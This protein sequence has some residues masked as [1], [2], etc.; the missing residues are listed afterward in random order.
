M[1]KAEFRRYCRE[2]RGEVHRHP[3]RGVQAAGHSRRLGRPLPHHELRLRGPD[4][5]GAGQVH[6][7]RRGLPGQ[8]A[9][10]LVPSLPHRPGRGR[11]R[12][13]RHAPSPSIY[14][15]F[16]MPGDLCATSLPALEGKKVQRGHLDHHALDDPRQPRRRARPGLRVRRLR[17]PQGAARARSTSWPSGWPPSCSTRWAIAGVEGDRL[18][19]PPRRSNGREARHPLYDRPSLLILG[20][21]VTLDAGTGCVHTAPGHGQEDYE[22]GLR[23]GL[24]VYAPVDDAGPVHRRGR[25]TSRESTSSRRNAKVV[26]TL[27][28]SGSLLAVEQITHSYPHCWRCK[29]PVIFRSTA[30]GS[31]PWRRRACGKTALD[32]IEQ[33]GVDSALGPATASTT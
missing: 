30:S 22:V 29:K 12:V 23:Y 18:D 9:R 4:R 25:R 24:D 15:A 14:V 7:E 20:D 28:E 16:P 27:R 17:S 3:A 19:R 5:A 33:R 1:T 13:R 6:G 32:E 26:E 10:L 11:G 31:S 2:V 8:E 21:H